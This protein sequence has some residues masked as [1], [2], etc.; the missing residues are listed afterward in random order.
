[1]VVVVVVVVVVV[2][3]VVVVVVVGVVV[4]VVDVDFVVVVL[5]GRHCR[6]VSRGEHRPPH[7]WAGEVVGGV[8]GVGGEWSISHYPPV[9]CYELGIRG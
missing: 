6:P 2:G 5:V 9:R 3:A 4:V 8:R 1:M 7:L